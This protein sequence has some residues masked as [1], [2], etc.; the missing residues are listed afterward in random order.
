MK[1]KPLVLSDDFGFTSDH[2]LL[3]KTAG[4]LL[5]D[6]CGIDA[7][8]RLATDEIGYDRSLYA[9]ISEL[10]WVGLSLREENG[11]VGLDH[12][13][14]AL[15]FEQTGRYLLPS[16][17]LGSVLAASAIE[18]AGSDDQQRQLCPPIAEGKTV[19]TIA[20]SEPGSSWNPTAVSARAEPC[21]GGYTLTGTKTHVMWGASCNLVVAPFA[22]DGAVALFA[23]ALPHD[24]VTVEPEVS[25]DGTRRTARLVFDAAEIDASARLTGDG[26]TAFANL[27]VR[28]YVLLAAE[29]IGAAESMLGRTRDYAIERTQFN[30]QIGSFQAVKHPIVDVMIAVERARSVMIAAAT[31]L[32]EAPEGAHIPARMAKAAATDAMRFSVDRGVQLH[33]GYGFT[34]DCDA[35]FY[36]KR[37]LWSAATLG[38]ATHHRRHLASAL[39]G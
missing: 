12:L 38:D 25:V 22:A 6:K 32:D 23:I 33:G 39:I 11:G 3:R 2:D 19:A 36:F 24:G 7:I 30:R 8:R 5:S 14:L 13:S 18:L 10:G 26:E 17:L 29:M 31:A 27:Y 16:P 1:M 21:E 15:L 37:Y 4:R 9:E 35:H 28:G 34:W 20:L